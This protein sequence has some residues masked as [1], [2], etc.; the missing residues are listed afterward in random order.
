M[1]KIRQSDAHTYE[2]QFE[3]GSPVKDTAWATLALNS[4]LL[5]FYLE[6]ELKALGIDNPVRDLRFQ[7]DDGQSGIIQLETARTLNE[8]EMSALDS[9]VGK[10]CGLDEGPLKCGQ[11]NGFLADWIRDELDHNNGR[12]FTAISGFQNKDNGMVLTEEDLDF[13]KQIDLSAFGLY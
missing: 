6:D 11:P 1:A 3:L 12:V 13:S 4:K 7:F 2:Q 5:G 8:A 9:F 10:A